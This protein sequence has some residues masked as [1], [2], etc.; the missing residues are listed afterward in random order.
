MAGPEGLDSTQK[1]DDEST[2]SVKSSDQDD[3]ELLDVKRT[4]QE[5]PQRAGPASLKQ[6]YE[7]RLE[8]FWAAAHRSAEVHE[9][10]GEWELFKEGM[11]RL[12][13]LGALVDGESQPI[14]EIPGDVDDVE[15]LV[16]RRMER[17]MTLEEVADFIRTSLATTIDR[18]EQRR[19]GTPERRTDIIVRALKPLQDFPESAG[20]GCELMRYMQTQPIEQRLPGYYDTIDDIGALVRAGGDEYRLKGVFITHVVLNGMR[21]LVVRSPEVF[22]RQAL[23]IV[24]NSAFR[25][26]SMLS[27]IFNDRKEQPGE[28]A[29]AVLRNLQAISVATTPVLS[30]T[31]NGPELV[32]ILGFETSHPL[33]FLTA[34]ED[35]GSVGPAWQ[36][37]RV[38]QA[39]LTAMSGIIGALAVRKEAAVSRIFNAGIPLVFEDQAHPT[40]SEALIR[41]QLLTNTIGIRLALFFGEELFIALTQFSGL[42]CAV[43]LI[44]AFV[45]YQRNPDAIAGVSESF[46]PLIQDILNLTNW[47]AFQG[48]GSWV[49]PSLARFAAASGVL[50]LSPEPLPSFDH[51]GDHVEAALDSI[52]ETMSASKLPTNPI[53]DAGELIKTLFTSVLILDE[54]E[55]LSALVEEMI[56][57]REDPASVLIERYEEYAS[58][59]DG[60]DGRGPYVVAGVT[61]SEE[62]DQLAAQLLHQPRGTIALM[63]RQFT[64]NVNSVGMTRR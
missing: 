18:L 22:N 42:N 64:V 41:A 11:V 6:L 50:K 35:M 3:A 45:R 9:T 1:I 7:R 49:D 48:A 4:I 59:P 23:G 16:A 14:E 60:G 51:F 8:R 53:L 26:A 37:S 20:L 30:I 27:G 5:Q 25:L 47:T 55:D 28:R 15:L 52:R 56:S 12:A 29:S 57:S 32:Q 19:E 24:S 62:W 33:E 31:A 38:G 46:L 13:A 10:V 21:T 44:G 54:D 39:R 40:S 61:P 2:S 36:R 58:S 43:N 63:L 17:G 34:L